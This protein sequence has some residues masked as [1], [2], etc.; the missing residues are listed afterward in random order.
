MKFS[1]EG[2]FLSAW[3]KKG[4]GPGEFNLPHAVQVDRQGHIYVADRE[5]NRIQV[6]D[7]Q[8]RYLRQIEG[9]APY[10]MYLTADQDLFVA[11]DVPTELLS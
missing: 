4:T 6:F 1:R 9:L 11:D 10:G 7:E 8:G 3:G 2:K 5:N